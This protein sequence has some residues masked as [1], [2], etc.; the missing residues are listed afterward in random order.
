MS[1]DVEFSVIFTSTTVMSDV[2]LSWE[3][4]VSTLVSDPT[5]TSRTRMTSA[6]ASAAAKQVVLIPADLS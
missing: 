4:T 5:G 3:F 1:S 2:K 6:G